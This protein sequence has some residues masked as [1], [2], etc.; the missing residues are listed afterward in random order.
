MGVRLLR[1]RW[2]GLTAVM[3]ALLLV[4][5]SAACG[6]GTKSG[7]PTTTPANTAATPVSK[8]LGQGVTAKTIRL[9]FVLIDYSKVEQ[10]IHNTDGNQPQTYQVFVND[11]NKH[12]GVDGRQI[13]ASY[14][15]Y[16]PIGTAGP[17]EACTSLTEDKKVFATIG[18][19]YDPTGAGQLCFVNQHHSILITHEL[20]QSVLNKVTTPGL[21]LTVTATP[22]RSAQ[23]LLT[24]LQRQRTL[25]GKTVAVLG[26]TGTQTSVTGTLVPGLK[27]I[28]AKLGSTGILTISGEDTTLAQSQLESII[29]RWKTEGV[30]AVWLSGDDTVATQFVTKLRQEMPGVLLMTDSAA[31]AQHNAAAEP[32]PNPYDGMLTAGGLPA[33]QYFLQPGFQACAKTYQAAIGTR[34]IAPAD[35][36]PGP[37][38]NKVEV[39]DAMEVA[40]EDLAFFKYVADKVGPY[41]NWV[42][43]IDNLGD[44]DNVIPGTHYAS[45]HTGK[46]DA[47]DDYG[48]AEYSHTIEDFKLT[49]PIVNARTS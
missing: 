10:Y 17:L 48:L 45:I 14:S 13:V 9:G 31:S 18:V 21:M 37:D 46:Y 41:L 27:H 19:L 40:C 23:V 36:K 32:N 47:S 1:P 22:E 20:T 5:A 25:Q 26:E 44:I 38:G 2:R 11:I 42:R 35:L 24:L 29:E 39:Y 49:T 3:G 33:Q 15:T 12:G 28:G 6:S 34:V 43:T 16:T 7:G 4:F 30:D 8:T